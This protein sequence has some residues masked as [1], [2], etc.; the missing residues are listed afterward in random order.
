MTHRVD[1][2]G[3][4]TRRVGGMNKNEDNEN[5][6]HSSESGLTTYKDWI[7]N[8]IDR[9][10]LKEVYAEF[11]NAG[12]ARPLSLV[13]GTVNHATVKKNIERAKKNKGI[14]DTHIEAFKA[15]ITKSTELDDSLKL[16]GVKAMD[17]YIA[18]IVEL[19][20][21]GDVRNSSVPANLVQKH[22][23]DKTDLYEK[24][25][26]DGI[27]GKNKQWC[28]TYRT[29]H[30]SD[31]DWKKINAGT[32]YAFRQRA[33]RV[34]AA[35]NANAKEL[36][37]V[38][39]RID[40]IIKRVD[41]IFPEEAK[42]HKA[43]ELAVP[44]TSLQGSAVREADRR[45]ILML[46][47]GDVPGTLLVD[48]RTGN[49]RRPAQVCH[50]IR[51]LLQQYRMSTSAFG[52]IIQQANYLVNAVRFAG[53]FFFKAAMWATLTAL[54]AIAA[55]S[56]AW[57]IHTSV[58]PVV[59]SAMHHVFL[60]L[61]SL[62]MHAYYGVL[63]TM[64]QGGV[65]VSA[66]TLRRVERSR[67]SGR[68]NSTTGMLLRCVT[69]GGIWL[70]F[71]N[72]LQVKKDIN[73]NESVATWYYPWQKMKDNFTLVT[74][75][76]FVAQV[77]PGMLG[78]GMASGLSDTQLGLMHK[79]QLELIRLD[80][81]IDT[82]S[83]YT[84]DKSNID[85]LFRKYQQQEQSKVRLD[86]CMDLGNL[87]NQ[88]ETQMLKPSA[89]RAKLL[90]KYEHEFRT[91]HFFDAY[92]RPRDVV[93]IV[94]SYILCW[95]REQKNQK[96][97]KVAFHGRELADDFRALFNPHVED[98]LQGSICHVNPVQ[99]SEFNRQW[100]WDPLARDDTAV[101]DYDTLH[102]TPAEEREH[103]EKEITNNIRKHLNINHL[104]KNDDQFHGFINSNITSAGGSRAALE[105]LRNIGG[106]TH[107]ISE[108]VLWKMDEQFSIKTVHAA[109]EYEQYARRQLEGQ[110]R[111]P[112][113]H[114]HEYG[115]RDPVH[116]LK[117]GAFQY[118]DMKVNA[119]QTL[120]DKCYLVYGGNGNT[121]PVVATAG[122]AATPAAATPA[123]DPTAATHANKLLSD[124][125]NRHYVGTQMNDV[126]EATK[127]KQHQVAAC[128]MMYWCGIYAVSDEESPMFQSEDRNPFVM[129]KRQGDSDEETAFRKKRAKR[130]SAAMK[131]QFGENGVR[132][133]KEYYTKSKCSEVWAAAH[134]HSNTNTN[135]FG[136]NDAEQTFIDEKLKH[137][138]HHYR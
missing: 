128:L 66:R 41:E 15:W 5:K 107:S 119:F 91:H 73:K 34:K 103:E 110:S 86:L 48:K 45:Q 47:C 120:A 4:R 22:V 49:I 74:V 100:S 17:E 83:D 56:V 60:K 40:A 105:M 57:Q 113:V 125:L 38:V 59:G 116:V 137:A 129:G 79:Y 67:R 35:A 135:P 23:N 122:T 121:V 3:Y 54:L 95:D 18:A 65:A 126:V 52:R 72:I 69:T 118:K 31:T 102:D 51:F 115:Y 112:V 6:F 13:D 25:L 134:K 7:Q 81:E 80:E 32:Y 39:S 46:L 77:S 68:P 132:V 61:Q 29:T 82:K 136:T 26:V 94:L 50:H 8:T 30:P 27:R 20:P 71:S 1:T 104:F 123:A 130:V 53:W 19:F 37:V 11:E 42:K 76:Q 63:H 58:S 92:G 106:W 84:V 90:R 28:E 64:K 96:L 62:M 24:V 114:K 70:V 99:C 21:D 44:S 78:E 33:E 138:P 2:G 133:L 85:M 16:Q 75:A 127:Q 98:T 93:G 10:K 131:M 88:C 14:W 97:P 55:V 124:L 109:S 117:S 89:I 9:Y 36:P 101:H 111:A 12:N 43:Y 108:A 87:Y